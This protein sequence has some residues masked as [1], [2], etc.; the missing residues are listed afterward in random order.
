MMGY[1]GWGFFG[2]HALWW[3]FWIAVVGVGVA[4][5]WQATSR[6]PTEPETPLQLLQRRYAAGEIS[7]EEYAERKHTL[8]RD[9]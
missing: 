5:A 9:G 4:L 1:D 3:L 8:E 7:R 2:V 6:R